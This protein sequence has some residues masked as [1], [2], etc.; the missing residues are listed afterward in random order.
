MYALGTSLSPAAASLILSAGKKRL[1]LLIS[2]YEVSEC[3][4][5]AGD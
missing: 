3:Y 2:R 4:E 5:S 1:V